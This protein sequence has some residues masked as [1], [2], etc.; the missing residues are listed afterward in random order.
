[1]IQQLPPGSEI[2]KD[3]VLN[4]FNTIQNLDL[5]LWPPIT[6]SKAGPISI[7]P[8][9]TN[10]YVYFMK[11]KNGQRVLIDK[12]PLDVTSKVDLVK[13]ISGG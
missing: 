9:I 6:P 1:V 13:A 11:V 5:G 4:G 7:L 3:T 8:K 10:P 12:N 2:D